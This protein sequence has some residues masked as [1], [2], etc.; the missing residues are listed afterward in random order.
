[1]E[2]F[3]D[4]TTSGS[5]S[6][7]PLIVSYLKIA[8]LMLG[9]LVLAI[10]TG[11]V[12]CVIAKEDSLH[13]KYYFLVSNLLVTDYF[14]VVA[15]SLLQIAGLIM[16]VTGLQVELNCTFMKLFETP[17]LAS[18]LLFA[19]LG[20]DR[21]I[22]IAYPYRHRKLMTNRFV[23]SVIAA[24][25]VMAIT[26]TSILVSGVLFQYVPAFGECYG[27]N[28]FPLEYLFKGFLMVCSTVLIIAINVYLYIKILDSNK[29]RRDNMQ[30]AGEG[31]RNATNHEVLKS[32][33]KPAVSVLLLGGLDRLF[34]LAVPVTHITLRLTLGNDSI[35][36]LYFVEFLV[37][38]IKWCQLLC[39]PL[40]YGIY[41]TAIRKKLFDFELYHRIFHRQSRVVVLNRQ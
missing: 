12:L 41:M 26:T 23:G 10:P 4:T 11:L 20:I 30:L 8:M 6:E 7:V 36:R 25:W 24:V 19:T 18:Q 39:H 37:Q 5:Y 40:V 13:T 35:I 32:H 34:N 15:Q 33:I 9:S 22:A 29:T 28:G 2:P 16:H 38:S 1:M 3:N 17:V 21:F 14:G 31:S 27:L